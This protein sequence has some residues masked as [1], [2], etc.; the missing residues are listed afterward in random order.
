[1]ILLSGGP[2]AC[3]R[4]AGLIRNLL[5]SPKTCE[6][7]AQV[8]SGKLDRDREGNKGRECSEGEYKDEISSK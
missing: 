6:A 4:G 7:V 1:M 5:Y 8:T 3:H 2:K